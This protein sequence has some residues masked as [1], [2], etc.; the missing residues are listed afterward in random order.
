MCNLT[1]AN[2]E[3]MRSGACMI[4]PSSPGIR[5]IDA[6]TDRLVPQECV[7]RLSAYDDIDGLVDAL[8]YLH[9]NPDQRKLRSQLT[10]ANASKIIPVWAERIQTELDLLHGLAAKEIT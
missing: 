9:N 5:G 1:N 2:L 10:E 7:W 3:A 6:D 4:I 8:L